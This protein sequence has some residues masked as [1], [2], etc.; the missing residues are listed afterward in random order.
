DV[1]AG[2]CYLERLGA[3]A[4]GLDVD[5]LARLHAEGRA[6]D[7]LAV[8]HDVTVHNHLTSLRRG[9]RDG[10]TNEESVETG[11]EDLDEV[12][13]GQSLDAASL[14]EGDLQLLLADAVL[15][16]QALLLAKTHSVVGVG[17][18]LGAAVR[19]RSVWTLLEVLRCLGGEG[20]AQCPREAGL[21]T[22]T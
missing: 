4:P 9:A 20:D 3:F 13:T 10:R 1:S 8:D 21:A 16:A 17:L 5:E 6:V 14:F 7:E 2:R 22:C 12:L 15:G 11:L 18:A 19:A